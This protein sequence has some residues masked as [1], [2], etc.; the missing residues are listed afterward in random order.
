MRR[1]RIGQT[2]VFTTSSK[3]THVF[4]TSRKRHARH[5]QTFVRAALSEKVRVGR[6][7]CVAGQLSMRLSAWACLQ[8]LNRPFGA[9][10]QLTGE[11]QILD[12]AKAGSG[13]CAQRNASV[14]NRT[15]LVNRVVWSTSVTKADVVVIPV[16]QF[17]V[18]D[19]SL[20]GIAAR[21]YRQLAQLVIVVPLDTPLPWVH[22]ILEDH[23]WF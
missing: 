7:D 9:S 2:P 17:R 18:L 21:K 23:G 10:P 19:G 13:C 16:L 12:S 20:P 5:S 3:Q 15:R 1:H 4:T 22:S 11:Y 14:N 8:C 6:S